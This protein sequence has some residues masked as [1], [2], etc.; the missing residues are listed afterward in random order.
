M[1]ALHCWSLAQSSAC[2]THQRSNVLKIWLSKV[3]N[4]IIQ[5]LK[6]QGITARHLNGEG[7]TQLEVPTNSPRLLASFSD[8]LMQEQSVAIWTGVQLQSTI[9]TSPSCDRE[10]WHETCAQIFTGN[11]KCCKVWARARQAVHARFHTHVHLK[12]SR[13]HLCCNTSGLISPMLLQL[14]YH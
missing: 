6:G 8:I 12:S 13:E 2:G 5:V 11:C 1:D 9:Y 10:H 4:D 3:G 7:G 14:E